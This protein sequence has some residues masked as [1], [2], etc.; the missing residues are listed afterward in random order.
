MLQKRKKI[1]VSVKSVFQR[2]LFLN[3]FC[4]VLVSSMVVSLIFFFFSSKEIAEA[5]YSAHFEIKRMS[6]LLLPVLIGGALA[7]LVS[8]SILALFIPQKIAGPIY[9][10]EEDLREIKKGNFSKKIVLRD[11]DILKDF[12]STVNQAIQATRDRARALEKIQ[13]D[14]EGLP[15][16]EDNDDLLKLLKEARKE[17]N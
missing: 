11:K 13:T 7:S 1:N 16:G 9:R 2:W 10:M 6:D 17:L 5:Y 12:A 8:G 14:L 15:A 4:A 3:V